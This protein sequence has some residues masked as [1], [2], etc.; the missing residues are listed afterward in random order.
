MC[1]SVARAL[2]RPPT[3]RASS[4]LVGLFLGTFALSGCGSTQPPREEPKAPPLSEARSLA[5]RLPPTA[6]LATVRTL[7]A[8]TTDFALDLARTIEDADNLVFSPHSIALAL[9]MTYAGAA[10]ETKAQMAETLRFELSD[11]ELNQAFNT[12]DQWLSSRER[13]AKSADDEPFRMRLSNGLWAQVGHE[14]LP[15]YLDVLAEYYGAGVR[16]VDFE[17]EPTGAREIINREIFRQTQGRIE[18]LLP[19]DAIRPDTR[20]VLTNA[21]YFSAGWA[22]PF[23]QSR[24]TEGEFTKEDGESVIVPMMRGQVHGLHAENDEVRVAALPYDGGEVAMIFLLP[25]E[26]TVAELERDLDAATLEAL[27]SSFERVMFDM[28]LPRFS[29][30]TPIGLSDA[31]KALGMTDA[32]SPHEADFSRMDGKRDLYLQDVLHEAFVK[33]DENGTEAAAVT[34]VIGGI[35]SLPEFVEFTIDRPFLF[36]VRDLETGTTLFYGRITDPSGS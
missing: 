14:F 19:S 21:I 4:V 29:T 24:T 7:T 27:A 12:L 26:K 5:E 16:L 15:S 34:A 11:A 9:V 28:R 1:S 32:F 33:V 2:L 6:S 20:F 30:R 17:N 13:S 31:L 25:K 36:L 35:V 18:N 22:E 3:M 10:A 8:G 23:S